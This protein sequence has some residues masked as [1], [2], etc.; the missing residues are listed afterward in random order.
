MPPPEGDVTSPAS[1]SGSTI[2]ILAKEQQV[3]R[4][5]ETP[6]NKFRVP[7]GGNHPIEL[8]A[9]VVNQEEAIE[10]KF[11]SNAFLSTLP[12]AKRASARLHHKVMG[13]V[14]VHF[15]NN[16]SLPQGMWNHLGSSQI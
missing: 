14:D 10:R 7:R 6:Q 4:T 13:T 9:G 3:P 12:E 2:Y 8:P 5:Q 1:S 11:L 16:F 15:A